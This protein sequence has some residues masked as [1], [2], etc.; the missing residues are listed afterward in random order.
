MTE[1][2]K[3][4]RHISR[5]APPPKGTPA[6]EQSEE[7][8]K[9]IP[10]DTE[11]DKEIRR[12]FKKAVAILGAQRLNGS[13]FL[14][15][16]LLR[17][18]LLEYNG[19]NFQHGLRSMPSSFNVLEAFFEYDPALSLFRLPLEKDHLF[20]SLEFLD[21]A[22]SADV[23]D[24]VSDMPQ[25]IEEGVIYS[26]NVLNDPSE[27]TFSIDDGTEYGI[28][29]AALVRHGSEVSILLVAGE[30]TDLASR[31][32]ELQEAVMGM[33][34]PGKEAIRPDK[35]R[36][37]EAV[38]LLESD[39]F[40]QIVVLTRMDLD[41]QTFDVRY[42]MH[43]NGDGYS[44]IT[45]DINSLLDVATGDFLT[46]ELEK[47]AKEMAQELERYK[48]IFELCKTVLY[49]PLYF[50]RN[51]DLV[52][53]ERHPTKWRDK[54]RR[55]T[56]KNKPKFVGP[57]ENLTHR[58]VSV[59]HAPAA[60]HPDRTVYKAPEFKVN[61]SGY[62]KKLPPGTVG[63]DKQ[64]R[65]IHGRTWIGKVLTWLQT[66]EEPGAVLAR[67]GPSSLPAGAD[68][69]S[70]PD[71]GYIY[72]MRSAAHAKDVFKVGFTRRS[73]EIRSDEISRTTGAP[74]KF[75]VA[76]EWKVDN[77]VKAEALIHEALAPCRMSP[78]RE[79]FRVPYRVLLETIETVLK[80]LEK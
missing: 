69:L 47:I 46:P 57:R 31:T 50:A 38:A 23:T 68:S 34:M 11:G 75:L 54:L 36:K 28:G 17:E 62:W 37:R 51:A 24:D 49:L 78:N 66:D 20:S 74:D 55:S 59:L 25:C 30:K 18:F 27:I 14:V 39:Q 5:Y 13:G 44:V 10:R 42:V 63:G 6:W 21:Y 41:Q 77:C 8:I 71:K 3:R 9:S 61:V 45:D 16:S 52:V 29:G 40:W 12:R 2:D 80:T 53:D 43:D 70:A 7:W 15:D 65:P 26:Y 73:T 79:F 1:H 60:Q 72:A 33:A 56:A 35:N 48:T 4:M 76:Q 22:T 58:T 67:R 64:G 32:K 19:R